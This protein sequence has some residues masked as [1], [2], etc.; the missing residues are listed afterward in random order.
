MHFIQHVAAQNGVSPIFVHVNVLVQLQEVDHAANV[1]PK[2]GLDGVDGRV[3]NRHVFLRD[4]LANELVNVV[5]GQLVEAHTD[6]FVLQRRI[7]LADV[8]AN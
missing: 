5:F 2:H 7:D 4:N 1:R 3:A 6:E 8:I